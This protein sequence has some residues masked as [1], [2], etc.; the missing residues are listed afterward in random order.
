MPSVAT[1]SRQR[2]AYQLHQAGV[3]WARVAQ[4]VGYANGGAARHAGLAYA[5]RSVGQ[6]YNRQGRRAAAAAGV[7]LGTNVTWGVE[8]EVESLGQVGAC[9]AV[10]AA[11]GLAVGTLQPAGYHQAARSGWRS[12]TVER[13]GSLG[14]GGAEVVSPVLRGLGDLEQA[15]QVLAALKAAGASTSSRCG[16][17]VHV[18]VA[19][20]TNDQLDTFL[21]WWAAG[22]AAV[23]ALLPA[24]R[25][26][27]SYARTFTQAWAD[28][29]KG[30]RRRLVHPTHME[31]YLALNLQHLLSRGT[32]EVRCQEG[33]TSAARMRSWVRFVLAAVAAAEAGTLVVAR[34]SSVAVLL[35]GLDLS[36][37]TRNALLARAGETAADYEAAAAARLAA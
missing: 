3:S 26:N 34:T 25:R 10:E 30:V 24:H 6:V 36:V 20:L 19:H 4:Q 31:R 22:S 7:L 16:Q 37:A 35:Q 32:L 18:S 15:G 5:A 9:R 12:W 14:Q 33:H 1:N 28:Q 11:L 29:G 23:E 8:F 17:H 21:D 27:A 2:E 13:D